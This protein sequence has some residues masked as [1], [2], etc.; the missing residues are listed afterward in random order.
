[1][2]D[3]N[4]WLDEAKK[5]PSAKQCGMYLTHNGVVRETAKATVR[6]GKEADLVHGMK[7]SYDQEKVVAEGNVLI[8]NGKQKMTGDKGIYTPTTKKVLMEGNVILSQGNNQVK[9][10]KAT[11]N[12]L[13]GESDLKWACTHCFCCLNDTWINAN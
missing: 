11:L 10:D 9:G 5:D 12:L 1:M 8:N 3:L 7:F 13:T 2:I 6:E 4:A